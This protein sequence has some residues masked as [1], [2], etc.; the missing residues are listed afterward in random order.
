MAAWTL[1]LASLEDELTSDHLIL[2]G[3]LGTCHSSVNVPLL[4]DS[5]ANGLAFIDSSFAQKPL[6]GP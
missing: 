2:Q 4:I 6:Y 3:R 5:G 1:D